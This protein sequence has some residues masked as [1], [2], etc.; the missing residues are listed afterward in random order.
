MSET[1]LAACPDAGKTFA[2]GRDFNRPRRAAR[3]PVTDSEAAERGLSSG[4]E[5]NT[6]PLG[7]SRTCPFAT[8]QA[9]AGPTA[10]PALGT[11]VCRGSGDRLKRHRSRSSGVSRKRQHRWAAFQKPRLASSQRRRSRAEMPASRGRYSSTE[12]VPPACPATWRAGCGGL[13]GSQ[14][15]PVV[16][17]ALRRCRPR[18]SACGCCRGPP[19][20][21]RRQFPADRSVLRRPVRCRSAP[22]LRP[23]KDRSSLQRTATARRPVL[24]SASG[25]GAML[26]PAR[27][28]ARHIMVGKRPHRPALRR[29]VEK[30]LDPV[31][32]EGGG[33]VIAQHLEAVALLQ[34]P[35]RG[36]FAH[37]ADGV[38]RLAHLAHRQRAVFVQ[39]RADARQPIQVLRAVLVDRGGAASRRGWPR[40]LAFGAVSAG[41]S[42]NCGSWK[43]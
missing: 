24:A 7:P 34:P 38:V 36:V 27:G 23:A 17:P 35:R 19:V 9:S 11:S 12:P 25:A 43:K 42:R 16:K 5:K 21:A 1:A 37:Q 8:L 41:L 30:P 14:G 32:E 33:V 13:T 4:S 15:L 29:A 6:A 40:V 28:M 18:P 39:Q 3:R 20:R 22:T 26:R 31:A 10:S 2:S